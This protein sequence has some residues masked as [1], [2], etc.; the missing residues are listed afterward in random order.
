AAKPNL[1]VKISGCQDGCGLHHVADFGFRGMGKKI[2]GRNAPHYQMYVG[3]DER[4]NGHIGLSGP[5][6]PARLAKRALTLMLDGY[7]QT[8][9]NGETVR[10]WALRIGKDGLR[11][12]VEPVERE[13]DP[14]NEGLFF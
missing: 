12:I 1:S 13:I 2:G 7:A 3:G 6:V 9:Q 4:K 8:K 11:A 10:D 14:A 5:V